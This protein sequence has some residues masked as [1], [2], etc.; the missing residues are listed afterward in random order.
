MQSDGFSWGRHSERGYDELP[1]IE[2]STADLAREESPDSLLVPGQCVAGIQARQSPLD[3][4]EVEETPPDDHDA[5]VDVPWDAKCS[6]R[7]QL[8]GSKSVSILPI[9]HEERTRWCL[10]RCEEAPKRPNEEDV[11]IGVVEELPF[12]SQGAVEELG[13]E[14]VRPAKGEAS[15]VLRQQRFDPVICVAA[16]PARGRVDSLLEQLPVIGSEGTV[17][18]ESQR[19][20]IAAMNEQRRQAT[21]GEAQLPP[22]E[23]SMDAGALLRCLGD[24]GSVRILAS[25]GGSGGL[26]GQKLAIGP[27]ATC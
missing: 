1:S 7:E 15:R 18:V 25:R 21:N 16:G 5:G 12:S 10:D 3:E 27:P 8:P 20:F 26:R 4:V 19:H 9:A 2:N 17:I 11:R 24:H 22:A 13:A 14:D 6:G 23:Q